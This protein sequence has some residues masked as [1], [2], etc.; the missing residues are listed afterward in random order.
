MIA[1]EPKGGLTPP[2]MAAM[3]LTFAAGVMALTAFNYWLR[4]NQAAWL[5][6]VVALVLIACA[7]VI[8]RRVPTE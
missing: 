2:V 7:I 6:A 8:A 4:S 1:R 3:F 5:F